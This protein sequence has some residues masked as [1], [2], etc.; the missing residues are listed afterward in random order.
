MKK[1]VKKMV[2][3][4]Y[5]EGGITER[6][7]GE[8]EPVQSRFGEDMLEKARAYTSLAREPMPGG[9]SKSAARAKAEAPVKAK[10][11]T[12]KVAADDESSSSA[13]LSKLARQRSPASEEPSYR[14]GTLEDPEYRK[15]LEKGQ[16]LERVYPVEEA[17]LGGLGLKA[18]AS[19]AKKAFDAVMGARAAT[20]AMKKAGERAA[21]IRSGNVAA[22]TAMAKAGERA[23]TMRAD[24][25]AEDVM[26]K[27][28]ER[29]SAMR[30]E[31]AKKA[32]KAA[33][34]KKRMMDAEARKAA[35]KAP[36]KPAPR[37]LD[38]ERMS[39]EGGA[40]RKGGSVRGCG[41][42]RKG[43]TKGKMR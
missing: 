38:E 13:E 10:A 4:R 26:A 20:T 14:K 11:A 17:A 3:R 41:I 1:P 23:A 39:G 28:S 25:A 29:A 6:T 33:T 30:G 5:A 40:F 7:F 24:R 42:A 9:G 27:A 12:P 16:A 22:D 37:N 21:S 2:K 35:R 36:E 32:E 19:G 18:A 34:F 8:D 43:L 15:K 31:M